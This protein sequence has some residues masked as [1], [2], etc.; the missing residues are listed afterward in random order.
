MSDPANTMETKDNSAMA[1]LEAII[2]RQEATI[3]R[4]E[5]KIDA[6]AGKLDWE[7]PRMRVETQQMAGELEK[8]T[9]KTDERLAAIEA[10]ISQG[11]F[12]QRPQLSPSIK[13]HVTDLT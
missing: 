12:G 2:L 8:A 3:A 11:N 4:Q 13:N 7:I 9:K 5:A 10:K 1:R 6:I